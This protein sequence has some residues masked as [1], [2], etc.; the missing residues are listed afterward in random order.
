MPCVLQ[1]QCYFYVASEFDI[2]MKKELS[3]FPFYGMKKEAKT[4]DFTAESHLQ[5]CYEHSHW[6]S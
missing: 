1:T 6:K 5:D 2:L 3:E 4:N